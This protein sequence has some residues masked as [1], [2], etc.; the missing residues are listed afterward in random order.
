MRNETVSDLI[1]LEMR[2][3]SP[4]YQA[5]LK[6]DDGRWRRYSTK[7]T[8][9]RQAL[10]FAEDKLREWELLRNFGAPLN[11][12][13]FVYVAHEYL[14][15]LERIEANG[16]AIASHRMYVGITK[17]WL[18]PFFGEKHLLHIDDA[19]MSD[20]DTYR[21][22][23]MGREPAKS[24]INK[25]NIVLRNLLEFA[26]KRKWLKQSQIPRLTLKNKGV[27]VERRGFFEPAEW[28]RLS[29]FLRAWPQSGQTRKTR[30]KRSVLYHYAT[31]IV[32]SGLRPGTETTNIRWTDFQ[33]VG[34]DE[35]NPA[36]YKI[37]V[38]AGKNA[39]RRTGHRK[40]LAHRVAV[41]SVGVVEQLQA[42]KELR[43]TKV[44]ADDLVFCM[45]DG[46]PLTD[47]S[48]MFTEALERTQLRIGITGE[49]RSLYSLRHSY[50]TWRLR[51]NV[52]Y[53]QLRAQMGTSLAMLQ[54]HY[55]HSTADNWVGELLIDKVA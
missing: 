23:M 3:T 16:A 10:R 8:D 1:R 30:Y 21:R 26:V 14:K 41:V 24:T 49:P 39:V 47:M 55:D 29:E 11:V 19:L 15:E 25:H 33:Y 53:E 35:K 51:Q 5:V 48:A 46:S 4:Y 22:D 44:K 45:A 34:G 2:K 12:K 20:F 28:A 31:L 54:Q 37:H 43:T 40:K 42:L 50:A 17:T 6:A 36:Y 7:T 52:S 38:R 9:R 13:R 27:P 18:L 32:K